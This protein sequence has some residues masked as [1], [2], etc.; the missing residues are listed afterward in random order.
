[1]MWT[2]SASVPKR[3]FGPKVLFSLGQ[4]REECGPTGADQVWC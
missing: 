4:Y 3:S 2:E 1:M